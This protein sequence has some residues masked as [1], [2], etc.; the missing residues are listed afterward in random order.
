MWSSSNH[1]HNDLSHHYQIKLMDLYLSMSKIGDHWYIVPAYM[2]LMKMA[3]LTVDD[4]IIMLHVNAISRGGKHRHN[5]NSSGDSRKDFFIKV[6]S[7]TT[8]RLWSRLRWRWY[9][10][11]LRGHETRKKNCSVIIV[12]PTPNSSPSH[13][14]ID[15]LLAVKIGVHHVKVAVV[16]I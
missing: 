15:C 14:K 8:R 9:D 6:S 12:P 5:M 1:H 13:I 10:K 4:T 11:L 3:A 7:F 2:L 16:G